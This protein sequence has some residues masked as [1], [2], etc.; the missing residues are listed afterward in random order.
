MT[1]KVSSQ[2]PGLLA[3]ID[4]GVVAAFRRQRCLLHSTWRLVEVSNSGISPC[5]SVSHPDELLVISDLGSRV[6]GI[7]GTSRFVVLYVVSSI[8]GFVAS[9]WWSP[10]SLS[11]GA[12]AA[13]CGLIGAMLAYARLTGSS[14]LWS[15][16]I[17]WI[18]MIA[19]IGLLPGW[20]ID[21]AH[22]SGA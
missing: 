7:F 1:F 14:M 18:I 12:S 13:A 16:Y 11:I 8:G 5:G 17:R 6:E 3:G 2:S 4:G 21:N 9:L 20:H 15:F 19:I 22:I 10:F